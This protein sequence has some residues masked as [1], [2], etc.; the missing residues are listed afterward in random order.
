MFGDI[1][2]KVIVNV[3]IV[4]ARSMP[5][6][7]YALS[8]CVVVVGVQDLPFSGGWRLWLLKGVC[9]DAMLCGMVVVIGFI[10]HGGLFASL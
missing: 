1:H 7:F 8:F 3:A 5:L 10:Y 6:M 2:G 9:Y 4:S